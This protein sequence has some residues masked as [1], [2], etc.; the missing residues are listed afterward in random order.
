MDA[1]LEKIKLFRNKWRIIQTVKKVIRIVRDIIV[2]R[3]R[4]SKLKEV[5][6]VAQAS[7]ALHLTHG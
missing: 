4:E 3:L 5:L 2:D 1:R 7:P 6:S